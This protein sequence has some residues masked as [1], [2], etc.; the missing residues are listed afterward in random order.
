MAREMGKIKKIAKKE[1]ES[2][3]KADENERPKINAGRGKE[4]LRMRKALPK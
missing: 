3:G 2:H 1:I 4:N